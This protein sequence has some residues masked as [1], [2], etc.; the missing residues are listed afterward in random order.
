MS[1]GAV[2]KWCK[3]KKHSLTASMQNKS[4]QEIAQQPQNLPPPKVKK[5]WFVT[6]HL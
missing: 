1:I 6:E 2:C 4:T 3:K 5:M